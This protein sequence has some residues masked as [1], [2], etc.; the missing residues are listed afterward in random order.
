MTARWMTRWK[1]AV[2][3]EFE[4]VI[5]NQV[6]QFGVDIVHKAVA[7]LIEID[8]AGAH[9]GDRILVLDQGQQQVFQRGKFMVALIGDR[10]GR[11]GG[12]FRGCGK[13][14][15]RFAPSG[16]CGICPVSYGRPARTK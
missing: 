12:L 8:V 13:T 4:D 16:S 1:P 9:D 5:G 3:F 2:G 11:G 6:G 10:P 14:W 7:Q 15:A